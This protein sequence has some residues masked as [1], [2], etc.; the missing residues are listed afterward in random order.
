MNRLMLS[1]LVIR[2]CM[3]L[4]CQPKE[5]RSCL[6]SYF[7]CLQPLR[8]DMGTLVEKKISG[9]LQHQQEWKDQI[10][11]KGCPSF[12]SRSVPS[13]RHLDYATDK[14]LHFPQAEKAA[15][16]WSQKSTETESKTF[17]CLILINLDSNAKLWNKVTSWGWGNI[18]V[19][20]EF[21]G[22]GT[23][24]SMKDVYLTV[25]YSKWC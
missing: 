17:I 1:F 23:T 14:K 10:L 7:W 9:E 3:L 18:S 6:W 11:A 21:L 20:R 4:W 24:C 15:V 19:L 16:L 13:P 22:C 12:L 2:F 25:V 5:E 8:N